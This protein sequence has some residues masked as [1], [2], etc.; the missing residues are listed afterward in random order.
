MEIKRPKMFGNPNDSRTSVWAMSGQ[1]NVGMAEFGTT[2]AVL[3]HACT[4]DDPLGKGPASEVRQALENLKCLH[5]GLHEVASRL[6]VALQSVLLEPRVQATPA[7]GPEA[8]CALPREL[9]T[10]GAGLT[11]VHSRLESI[12]ARLVL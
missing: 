8:E 5:E 6:E 7:A 1:H 3:N 9:N 4:K 2:N 11:H 12:L 10:V